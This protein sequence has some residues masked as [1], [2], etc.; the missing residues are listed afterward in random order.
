M[1]HMSEFWG[2]VN[3]RPSPQNGNWRRV[4]LFLE[5]F[6]RP[7]GVS[8]EILL[9]L[10]YSSQRNSLCMDLDPI[11]KFFDIFLGLTL[12]GR[13][14]KWIAWDSALLKSSNTALLKRV[15]SDVEIKI[16]YI[17]AWGLR[18]LGLS[19]NNVTHRCPKG[20]IRFL[21]CFDCILAKDNGCAHTQ[22]QIKC[23]FWCSDKR[24]PFLITAIGC[25]SQGLAIKEHWR[26]FGTD[27]DGLVEI[28]EMDTPTII[29]TFNKGTLSSFNADI[30]VAL[31]IIISLELLT[32]RIGF[33]VASYHNHDALSI[34]CARHFNKKEVED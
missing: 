3:D 21:Q 20:L 11:A 29:Y 34:T 5:M 17:W 23:K 33:I 28:E 12:Y 10:L 8:A 13:I 32:S 24:K 30:N 7:Q 14:F 6:I 15:W 16:N 9:K 1:V 25:D 19:Y 4:A 22:A 2:I 18:E 27:P 31:L 26:N